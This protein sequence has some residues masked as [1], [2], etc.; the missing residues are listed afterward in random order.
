MKDEQRLNVIRALIVEFIGTFALIFVGAGAII[1]T[2][3][4]NLVAIALA[5]GL[6]IGL[7]VAAAGHISGGVYNPAL[8]VGLAIARKLTPMLVIPYIVVQLL[9]ATAAAL[10]LKGV[11]PSAAIAKVSLGVPAVGTGF[12]T[13]GAFIAEVIMTFFLMFVVYGTAVDERGPRAIAGL[14]IGLTITMDIFVGGGV[15]GAAMNPARHFGP[16]LIGNHWAN[17]W[18]WWVAPIVGAL[19]AAALYAY[20]LQEQ[21]VPPRSDVLDGEVPRDRRV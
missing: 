17:W 14:A 20:V 18:L 11:F 4:G 13:G 2:E 7:L 12:G 3:G 21:S 9:G 10:C 16:A 15:S 5:H 19:L 1:A 6:A 8:T